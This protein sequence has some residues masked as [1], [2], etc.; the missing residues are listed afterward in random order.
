MVFEFTQD[1]ITGIDTIDDE[2]RN[3]FALLSKA[4]NLASTEY[5][6]DYYQEVKKYSRGAGGICGYTLYPRG[7]IH[8]T[9]PRPRD[10]PPAR[11]AYLFPRQDTGVRIC[12]YR[13]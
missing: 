11:A 8:D 10:N 4:Y 12:E 13:P 2:H 9:N 3:L 5:H 7:G 6:S 1:C